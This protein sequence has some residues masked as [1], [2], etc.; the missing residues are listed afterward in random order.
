MGYDIKPEGHQTSK[1][2][3]LI[4]YRAHGGVC[5]QVVV[6]VMFVRSKKAFRWHPESWAFQQPASYFSQPR[7]MTP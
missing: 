3:M 5:Q 7:A 2:V 6:M 4:D 1:A